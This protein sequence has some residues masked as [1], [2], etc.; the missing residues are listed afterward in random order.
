MHKVDFINKVSQ[1]SKWPTFL[2]VSISLYMIFI[3]APQELIM[4]DIQRIFYYHVASAWVAFF[5]FFVVFL[6][7]IYYLKKR[8][9]ISNVL[10]LAS[11]EI[12]LVFTTIVLITGPIWAKPVWNAWWTWDPRLTTTLILC[13]I[14]LAYIL[15]R[16]SADNEKTGV[17]AAV[18]GIIAF[19]NVPIVF[20]SVRWWSSIHPTVVSGGSNSLDIRM[21]HTLIVSVLAFSFLYWHILVKRIKLEILSEEL[22]E[23]KEALKKKRN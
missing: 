13:F 14:Y 23:I 2:L 5:A 1:F 7:S 12:G 3:Y 6:A 20:M 22:R 18:F 16:L 15:I 21:I 11:A 4:G 17:L 19:I 8:D 10:A 9:Y